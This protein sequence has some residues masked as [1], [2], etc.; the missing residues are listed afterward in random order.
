[1]LSVDIDFWIEFFHGSSFFFFETEFCPVVPGW[2]AVV[3]SPLFATSAF[4]VQAIL[5]LSLSSRFFCLIA[6]QHTLPHP[7]NFCIFSRD[8]VSP[9]W[10]A[11]LEFLTS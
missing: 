11:D 7:A 2:S 5:L 4:Q 3:Q 6:F 8:G 10:Q 9:C 1:M